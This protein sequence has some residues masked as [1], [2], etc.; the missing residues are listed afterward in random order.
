PV[1]T[2]M[3][4]PL[5]GDPLDF[6]IAP[7]SGAQVVF[8]GS[9]CGASSMSISFLNLPQPGS[10]IFEIDLQAAQA[11][12]AALLGLGSADQ[13]GGTLPFTLPGGCHLL[14]SPD[15]V[16]FRMTNGSGGAAQILPVPANPG[17]TGLRLYG[18]WLQLPQSA[19]AVTAAIAVRVGP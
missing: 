16:L 3:A 19:F 6:A 2:L 1:R 15:A 18:Q 5:P 9:A 14:V 7:A 13:L 8:F 17:L 4:G 12:A 11:N 10:S